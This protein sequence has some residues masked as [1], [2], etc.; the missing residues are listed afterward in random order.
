MYLRET[1]KDGFRGG[2][3]FFGNGMILRTSLQKDFMAQT[4]SKSKK[5]ATKSASKKAATKKTAQRRAETR[6][7]KRTSKAATKKSTTTPKRSTTNKAASNGI[8]NESMLQELFKNELKDIYWAEKYLVKSLPKMQKAAESEELKNA[9]ADHIVVTEEQV[10]R[11]EEVFEM[12]EW[13]VQAKKCEGMEGL[14]EEGKQ[15]ME[16]MAKGPTRDAG[17]IISAQKVEHYEI[18]AYGGLA[19]LARTMGRTDVADLLSTT[20]EEEKETDMLLTQI[21]EASINEEAAEEEGEG[22]SEGGGEDEEEA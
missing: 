16:E 9:I 10:A 17:I 18:A 3:N 2:K 19:Q 20:L 1:M 12:M 8:S 7:T 4:R 11:L 14:I 13:K 6:T 5:S 21:A 22:E 15:V